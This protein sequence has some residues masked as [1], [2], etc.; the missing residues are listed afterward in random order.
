MRVMLHK[1]YPLPTS[2][3]CPAPFQSPPFV[4]RLSISTKTKILSHVRHGVT[5][6]ALYSRYL[7][8][9]AALEPLW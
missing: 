5:D 8:C 2:F 1:K 4:R 6:Y 9:V 3:I 7:G